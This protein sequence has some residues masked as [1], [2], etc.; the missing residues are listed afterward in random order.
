[1]ADHAAR[2]SFIATRGFRV[3]ALLVV[4]AVIGVGVW[5]WATSGRESTDDAQVDA[6]VTP[7]APRVGGTVQ[8]LPIADN[9]HVDAGTV[10]VALDPRD[11]EVAVAKARAELADAEASA[12]AATGSGPITSASAA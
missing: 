9:Q 11:F 4:M 7:I 2:S 12:A 1:M 3:G 6:H 10:L 8:K 5:Y